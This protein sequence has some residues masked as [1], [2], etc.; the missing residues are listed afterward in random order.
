MATKQ[1]R[2]TCRGEHRVVR[3]AN[4]QRSVGWQSRACH[5]TGHIACTSYFRWRGMIVNDLE[6]R[7]V[8]AATKAR[9]KYAKMSGGKE[10]LRHAPESFLQYEIAWSIV[11]G[12]ND[13]FPEGTPS[14][15]ARERGGS[16]LGPPLKLDSRVR[17]DIVV[18]NRATYTVRAVIEVKTKI[19]MTGISNDGKTIK[20]YL[21]RKSTTGTGYILMYGERKGT[22][23]LKDKPQK[24]V[25][26][27]GA[28]WRIIHE[29]STALDGVEKS[30]SVALL[31]YDGLREH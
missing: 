7:I 4:R 18:W 26:K 21:G 10:S 11:R 31:R 2:E 28:G 27:L 22:K 1:L 29:E 15:I 25:R 24:F 20:R 6:L 16:Q 9:K 14:K 19:N 12:G 17:F 23:Y 3:I 13:V 8:D 30:W 5:G